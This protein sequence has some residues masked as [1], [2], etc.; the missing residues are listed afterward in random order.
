MIFA[1][2]LAMDVTGLLLIALL[3]TQ[4]VICLYYIKALVLSLVLLEWHQL[5]ISAKLVSSLVFNVSILKHHVLYAILNQ[6]TNIYLLSTACLLAQMVLFSTL[7]LI[8]VL[9]AWLDA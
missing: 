6:L 5:I 9:A 3:V 8:N 4:E 2:N 1:N 7:R